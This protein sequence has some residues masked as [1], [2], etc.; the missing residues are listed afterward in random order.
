MNTIS[1]LRKKIGNSRLGKNITLIV[2]G[3]AF[4]QALGIIFSPVITRIYLPEQYGILTAYSAVLGLLAISASFDYQKAIPIEEDHNKAINILAL[5]MLFLSFS[6]LVIT[7][8]LALFG[9]YFLNLLD[10]QV[11]SSYKYLI[12][13]G[14]FFVGSYDIILQWS[15]RDRNYKV[16]T[17]TRISQSIAA[18]ITKVTL[19]IMKLGPIG[20]ILGFIIGQSAGITSLA[21]PLIKSKNVISLISTKK[22]QYA[23]KRYK[24]FPLYSAPSNYVY[25]AGNNI[26]VVL[27]TSIF[28][29]SVTGFFGLANSIIRLPMNLIGASVAQVFYSEAANIGK[30]NP[31]EIKRLSVKLIKKLALIALVPLIT[32]LLFGPWLF[33]FVFG[34]QWYEAGIY[35]RILSVMVYFHFIILPISRILEIFERQREGL[36]FN[37]IRLGMVLSVFFIAKIFDFSSYQTIALYSLSNSITYIGLL[38]MVLN[39]MNKEIQNTTKTISL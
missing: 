32:L 6:V 13:L 29:S 25:T 17:R 16:I 4:A 11:L 26:P 5:A 3:T 14:V 19:G 7:V 15:F 34:A 30:S 38:I 21:S 37:V 22:L 18:N 23:L 27:L 35:A 10:S 24:N 39:I 2:G 8:L 31:K 9:D 12:P 20:L 1:L 33:S 28:G 36:I